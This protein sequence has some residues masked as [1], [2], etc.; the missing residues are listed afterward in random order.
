MSGRVLGY[1]TR[2]EMEL[3]QTT[4]IMKQ[5][6]YY[7]ECIMYNSKEDILNKQK[8]RHTYGQHVHNH[9]FNY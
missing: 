8:Y 7:S 3:F 9:P 5:T 4:K 2:T 1:H 6:E